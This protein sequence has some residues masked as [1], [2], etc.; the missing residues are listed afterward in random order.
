MTDGRTA[1]LTALRQ[2]GKGQADKQSAHGT[3]LGTELDP[4]PVYVSLTRNPPTAARRVEMFRAKAAEVDA[5]TAHLGGASEVAAEIAAYLRRMGQDGPI[6]RATHGLIEKLDLTVLAPFE[7][8]TGAA[9]DEDQV[10]LSVAWA[11]IAETGTLVLI[12]A[13]ETPTSINFLPETHIV[14]LPAG[15]IVDAY[16]EVWARLRQEADGADFMAPAIN[17]ITGPS[18]TADIEQRL[19][20]GVHGPRHLHILILENENG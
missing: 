1:I 18:R 15:R 20:L 16:E 11:G 17:W 9:R 7:I 14:L 6:R 2:A 13:P 8:A 4:D 3:D 19:Q 10:G 12:S 5:T